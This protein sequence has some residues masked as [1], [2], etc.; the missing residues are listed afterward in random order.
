MLDEQARR[1]VDDRFSRPLLL[2]LTQTEVR[3]CRNQSRFSV[4]EGESVYPGLREVSGGRS[5]DRLPLLRVCGTRYVLSSPLMY[6]GSQRQTPRLLAGRIE[7]R[8]RDRSC[9]EPVRPF[10][11]AA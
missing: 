6:F 10:A 11:G 7:D 2:A 1:D 8:R 9:D 4:V 5:G 3:G